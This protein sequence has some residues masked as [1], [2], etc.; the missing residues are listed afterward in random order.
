MHSRQNNSNRAHLILCLLPTHS[1]QTSSSFRY[2]VRLHF[3]AINNL[4]S[5][6]TLIQVSITASLASFQVVEQSS[7]MVLFL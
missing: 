4:S 3:K 1:L 6:K 7:H 2:K 5:S